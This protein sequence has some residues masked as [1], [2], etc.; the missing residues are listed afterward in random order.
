MLPS[1]H[2][3][4]ARQ[5]LSIYTNGPRPCTKMASQ[6]QEDS[7]S[8]PR[9][10][11][12]DMHCT[13]RT[14]S[15]FTTRPR[16]RTNFVTWKTGN[17]KWQKQKALQ[18]RRHKALFKAVQKIRKQRMPKAQGPWP[19][20]TNASQRVQLISWKTRTAWYAEPCCLTKD[21]LRNSLSRKTSQGN[22]SY[23]SKRQVCNKSKN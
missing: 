3:L 11:A 8:F 23:E 6:S 14:N 19:H 21:S 7:M 20:A 5:A 18:Q 22:S 15:W 9:N 2:Q 4:L 17:K 12:E 1:S 10:A 13:H 16:R